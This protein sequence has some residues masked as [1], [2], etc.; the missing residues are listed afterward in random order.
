MRCFILDDSVMCQ[1]SERE[2]PEAVY[3]LRAERGAPGCGPYW[4]LDY[5]RADGGVG[6]VKTFNERDLAD[7]H[8]LALVG[9][10]NAE[11]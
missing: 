3:W 9:R 8:M 1:A 4:A 11:G 6:T 7:D 5:R 2:K 10:L